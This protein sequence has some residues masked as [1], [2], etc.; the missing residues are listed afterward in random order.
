MAK[1]TR[2]HFGLSKAT[3]VETLTIHWKDGQIDTLKNLPGDR[4][5]TVREGGRKPCS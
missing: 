5:I 3:S 2:V 4:H 1:P